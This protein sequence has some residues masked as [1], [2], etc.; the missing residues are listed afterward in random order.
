MDWDHRVGRR[1]KLHDLHI[2]L[3]VVQAGSM[4]KAATRLAIS[5]PSISRTIAEMEHTLGVP[6]LDR[7]SQGVEPTQY[8]R[9][10]LKRGV[11]VFEEL[12]QTVQDIEFLSDPQSGELRLGSSPAL[13]EGIVLE[14]I[15]RLLGGHPR[16]SFHV[17]TGEAS[18]LNQELL[19]RKVEL[20]I[21][22]TS[23][24]P[25]ADGLDIEFLFDEPLVV[26]AGNANPWTRRRKIELAELLDERWTWPP[27]P[28]VFDAVVVEAFGAAGLSPPRPAVYSHA[29]NVRIMLAATRGFLAIIPAAMLQFSARD[30]ALKILPV[31]LPMTRRQIGIVTLKN[32]TLSPLAQLFIEIARKVGA[33]MAKGR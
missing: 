6:L 33:P 20:V 10:V 22:R 26:V 8:G 18:T 27:P 12:R 5:Q 19:D 13:A 11:A 16:V 15:E 29:I 25:P 32:R 9:A 21:T 23:R 3:A 1:L 4:A 2:L 31:E 17:S 28:S 24:P 14:I 30:A 7:S